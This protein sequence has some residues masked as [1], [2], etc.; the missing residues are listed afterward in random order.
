M[1]KGEKTHTGVGSLTLDTRGARD[2]ELQITGVHVGTTVLEWSKDNFTTTEVIP[3]LSAAGAYAA[4]SVSTVGTF[5]AQLPPIPGKVRSR[6][7]AYTSGSP[8]HVLTLR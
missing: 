1:K 7:S 5:R 4:S 8:K 2:V 3:L 6:I